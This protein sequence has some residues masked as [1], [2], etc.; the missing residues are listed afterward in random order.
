MVRVRRGL[1]LIIMGA[2]T[3]AAMPEGLRRSGPLG[4]PDDSAPPRLFGPTLSPADSGRVYSSVLSD[5]GRELYFF[6]HVG[7]GREDYRIF[8]SVRGA[9]A[10]GEPELVELGG[11]HSDLYPSLSVD[12]Q[13][14]VFASYRPVS[15]GTDARRNAH[16][17]LARRTPGGWTL[18]QLLR[19]SRL[20]HYHSG[21]RQ[22]AA[23]TLFFDR[24]TPDW[25]HTEALELAWLDTAYASRPAVSAQPAADYWRAR[26]GDSVYVWGEVPGPPGLALLQISRVSPLGGRR[27]PAR[28]FV[29]SRRAAGWSP[30]APAGGG[31]GS[32]APNFAW[33]SPDGCYVT[34]TR[35]YATFVRVA[36]RKVFGNEP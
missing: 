28:Y 18:P 7:P 14:L 33:L 20:G 10:W 26:L 9:R 6:K 23:G 25:R 29:T 35:N 24:T 36:A 32:G 13:R 15:E 1:L 12:G 17:W 4:C 16:L 22:N 19:A 21:L 5:D 34:Y 27:A 2:A 8:R 3:A 30:L 11:P 31:L